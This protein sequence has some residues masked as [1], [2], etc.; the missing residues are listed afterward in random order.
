MEFLHIPRSIPD[1]SR[2][3]EMFGDSI[4]RIIHI[5]VAEFGDIHEQA[6]SSNQRVTISIKLGDSVVLGLVNLAFGRRFLPRLLTRFTHWSFAMRV[7]IRSL[8]LG[9]G[10]L[11]RLDGWHFLKSTNIFI[12]IRTGKVLDVLSDRRWRF[13]YIAWHLSQ[14]RNLPWLLS[15]FH[16]GCNLCVSYM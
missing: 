5:P 9:L 14:H 16:L 10:D 3:K 7:V 8:F 2:G 1:L 13:W 15:R 11:F 4:I 12:I 6:E